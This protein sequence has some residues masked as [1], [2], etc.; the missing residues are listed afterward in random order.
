[1]AGTE[2]DNQRVRVD[3]KFFRLG[4]AKFFIKG[5][6]YGPFPGNG[7]G[8]PFPER[9]RT[10]ADFEQLRELGA[11]T[12]RV[13]HVPPRWLLDLAG[14]YGLRFLIDIPWWKTGC[15]LD[16]DGH[17]ENAR[18]AVREAV[19]A[20]AGHAAV[21]AYS[22]VN[23]IAPDVV[24]WH[25]AKAVGAFIDELVIEAKRIDPQCLVTFGNYP[26]T[27]YLSARL[28]D[29]VCFNIYLHDEKRFAEYLTHIQMLADAKPLVVGELGMDSTR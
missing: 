15:F 7:N 24:R 8:E 29:F 26:P 2:Q 18:R 16:G 19:R 10:K 25:G 4:E 27:E 28:V 11:N 1:M 14:E 23:E 20:G 13:Y 17:R 21:L 3:G 12:L 5:V 9:D 22:L 6:S